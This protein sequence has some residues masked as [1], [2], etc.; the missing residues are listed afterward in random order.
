MCA[1]K[2]LIG[3]CL[4]GLAVASP[5]VIPSAAAPRETEDGTTEWPHFNPADM[6]PAIKPKPTIQPRAEDSLFHNCGFPPLKPCWDEDIRHFGE[7][8]PLPRK[9][10]DDPKT[11]LFRRGPQ[12]P[13]IVPPKV[14]HPP[15]GYRGDEKE[16][17]SDPKAPGVKRDVAGAEAGGHDDPVPAG[18]VTTPT[19]VAVTRVTVVTTVPTTTTVSSKKSAA[20][21][22]AGPATVSTRVTFTSAVPITITTSVRTTVSEWVPVIPVTTSTRVPVVTSTGVNITTSTGAN[23]T[24]WIAVPT[25]IST[26]VPTT[27]STTVPTTIATSVPTTIS[28]WVPTTLSTWFPIASSA[29][30]TLAGDPSEWPGTYTK[31]HA[32]TTLPPLE[33]RGLEPEDI[34]ARQLEVST[35]LLGPTKTVV[36]Y[37]T[38]TATVTDLACP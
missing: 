23:I 28:K 36:S 25:T 27:I 14:P 1:V 22:A 5:I 2:K 10:T 9:A 31:P 8:P 38:V 12:V 3:V 16:D 17:G 34:A 30:S 13:H 33:A 26:T 29:V 18:P 20:S 4:I 37:V 35:E 15:A 7:S 24:T 21:T 6:T 32:K 11:P 19:G